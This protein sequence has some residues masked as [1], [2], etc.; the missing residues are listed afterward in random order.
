MP[1]EVLLFQTSTRIRLKK[2][3]ELN[4]MEQEETKEIEE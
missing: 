4:K 2:L 3:E 1:A